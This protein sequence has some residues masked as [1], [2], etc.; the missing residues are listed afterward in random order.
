[1]E[2]CI[3]LGTMAIL[4]ITDAKL[5]TRYSIHLLNLNTNIIITYYYIVSL[6]S[7]KWK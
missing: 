6:T 4:I 2:I 5:A 7:A 1:M 3:A